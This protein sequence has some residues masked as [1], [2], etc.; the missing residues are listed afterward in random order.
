MRFLVQALFVMGWQLPHLNPRWETKSSCAYTHRAGIVQ[1]VTI[2]K[3]VKD[4]GAQ[5]T[6]EHALVNKM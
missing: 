4:N 2:A 5:L 1:L 6:L 3:L